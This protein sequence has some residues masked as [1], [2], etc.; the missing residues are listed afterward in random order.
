MNRALYRDHYQF[1]CECY[2]KDAADEV[3]KMLLDGTYHARFG[4]RNLDSALGE[5]AK[6]HP[7]P[8]HAAL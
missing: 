3:A 5:I 2:G 6:A 1:L 8:P 4:D 7:T